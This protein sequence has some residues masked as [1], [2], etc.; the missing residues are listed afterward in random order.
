MWNNEK[1]VISDYKAGAAGNEKLSVAPVFGIKWII[2]A[3]QEISSLVMFF[4]HSPLR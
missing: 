1:T 2:E 4:A 3:C